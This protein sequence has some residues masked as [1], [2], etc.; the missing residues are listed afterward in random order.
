VRLLDAHGELVGDLALALAA[1]GASVG[2]VVRLVAR[3]WGLVYELFGAKSSL[4]S[5]DGGAG[6]C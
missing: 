3:V 6:R 4:E 2:R 1:H 5:V